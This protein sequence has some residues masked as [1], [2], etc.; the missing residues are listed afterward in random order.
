MG[1]I[2][3]LLAGLIFYGLAGVSAWAG[4]RVTLLHVNDVY[5]ILP[6]EG[7][8]GLA[9]LATVVNRERQKNPNTLFTLGGDLL[10][11]SLLSGVTRGA[12]MVE[13]FNAM[14]LEAA[15]PGNH[16]FD[17]GPDNFAL[18]VSASRFVWVATNMAEENDRPFAGMPSHLIQPVGE[19]KVGLLGLITPETP[20]LSKPGESVHFEAVEDAALEGVAALQAAGAEVIVALTHL[21]IDE[22]KRLAHAVPGIHVILGGH[23]HEAMT[24]LEHGVLILKAGSDA[25]QLGVVDLEVEKGENGGKI[26]VIPQWRMVPVQGAAPDPK[27]GAI[28]ERYQKGLEEALGQPIGRFVSAA[29]S[30]KE[31]IRNEET[32]IGNLITDAMRLSTG[33]EVALMNG[34]GIRGDRSY[35]AGMGLTPKDVLGELPFAN[36]TLLIQLH[37]VDLRLA[38][39]NGVSRVEE[40]SGRF[41]HLSG[42]TVVYDPARPAGSRLVSALVEGRPIEDKQLY[43]VALSDYLFTGHDGFEMLKGG[44]LLI[45][46]SG[47]TLTANQVIDWVKAHPEIRGAA[48]GRVTRAG[49]K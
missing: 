26:K 31:V 39:E 6:K 17:F 3:P 4:E 38:L 49:G 10:S 18:Q 1:R 44:Q 19:V 41:L 27:V 14:G 23:D 9:E 33:A 5:E 34:G 15:V 28:V 35:P 46:A 12:H 13:L 16:E 42:A 37:G 20:T 22:D 32:G 11:P 29:S 2:I 7:K 8:G 45:D 36:V 21:S 24:F 30:Q 47:A 40:K 43:K 25:E 48:E